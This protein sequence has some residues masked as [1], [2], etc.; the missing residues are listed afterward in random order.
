MSDV[1]VRNSTFEA[2]LKHVTKTAL[3][4]LSAVILDGQ[5]SRS[6]HVGYDRV[7]E[8]SMAAAVSTWQ[9]NSAQNTE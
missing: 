3:H 1:F 7:R 4:A 5:G 8:L 6:A 2:H 9:I